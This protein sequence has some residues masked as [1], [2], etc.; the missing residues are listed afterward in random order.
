MAG[1]FGGTVK[2]TGESEYTKALK[3]I[4]SNLTVMASEMKVV[5]SQYDKNDKSVQAITSRNSILNKQIEEGN[6]KIDTYNSALKNFNEQQDKNSDA[7]KELSSNLESENKKLEELKNNTSSTSSE[8]KAQEKVVKDLSMELASAESQYDKNNLM[9]NKYKKELN[10]AQAEVNNLTNELNNN[11]SGLNENKNS[12]QKLTD[13]IDNQKSKLTAL[14]EEYASVVLE[15][16][17]SSSEAKNLKKEIQDLS[18][19]IKENESRF[20]SATKEIDKFTKSEENAGNQTLKLSDLIKGNLI[21]E[22]IL[23]GVKGLT[24]AM[25]SMVGEMIDLGKQAIQSY[26]EYEQL[27]GGVETLFGASGQSVEEYAESVGKSVSEIQSEYDSLIEAQ[28]EVVKNANESYKTA[29]MSANEY[30]NTVTSFSASLIA[31]LDGDTVAAAKAANQAI[32]DMSDNA[33]KMGTDISMIQS[34]YQGFAK[35]NYTMLDNLKLGYGGTKTEMERLLADATKLSGVKYDISNLNDV[36]EAIHVIQDELGIAGATAKEASTTIEGSTKAMKSAWSNLV[37]GI[38]DDN[39]DFGSLITN[40]VDSVITMSDN[41]MPRVSV[42]LDGIVELILGLSETLLP[43]ILN[44]GVE[45]IQNLITGITG[46][47]GNLMSGVNQVINT[48]L[49]ALISMLP[50]IIQAGIQIIVSLIQGIG[51]S[52]PTLIP[53][54]ID[55]VVLIVET[56]L[57]N[58]GLIIDAGIQLLIGLAEGL[59][60]SLPNLIDKIPVIIDKLIMAITDNLPKIIA[61]GI[62]LLVQLAVGLVKSIP[63]LIAA[64]PKIISSLVK[65]IANYYSQMIS[66]GKELLGKIKD[67]IVDGIKKIPEV[68]KNLVQG[69]WN[70]INNAKDWVLDKIKGFGKSILNGIKSFF[71]INSPSKLFEDQIGKNLALGI[72]EGFTDEMDSVASDIENSIPTNFDLGINTNYGNYSSLENSLSKEVLVDAFKE[73]LSGMTFKA[74][75]ETFGELV[76]DNI[77]KVVYS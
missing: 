57:D 5:S 16:G 31:S 38:A 40:F 53:Q 39:A 21:S 70:G 77:E 67:G 55:C 63:N 20:D 58:I 1:S 71:G 68:G 54:I 74:F 59:I 34:A 52:L 18:E 17:K 6:K 7:I 60:E 9:I 66:Q 3:T 28:N 65:G 37:T 30:M 29:G 49:N 47:I 33:N 46:N 19:D 4:T 73:A 62:E 51:T 23:A 24:S 44:M 69:L 42:A 41:I 26:A 50:S 14:V 11:I 72:G 10:L 64:I 12:Y 45:L 35:Q 8:I 75:D 15:Q 22:A 61:M 43:E 32:I 27:I 56:L 76:I 25:G 13:T 48:I 2:L 36:Y